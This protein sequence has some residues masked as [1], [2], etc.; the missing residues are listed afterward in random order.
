MMTPRRLLVM[1]TGFG[2]LLTAYITYA[3]FLGH[4]GDFQP[5]PPDFR[6][7][8]TTDPLISP[9]GPRQNQLMAKLEEAFGANCEESRR[10]I[11]LQ[12]PAQ[13][14]VMAAD[15]YLITDGK[16]KLIRVSVAQFGKPDAQ[17]RAVQINSMR[18]DLA[19][20][21][22]EKPITDLQAA[23]RLKP[24]AG[25][26]DGNVR[27]HNN[28]GTP[29]I[30][31][32]LHVFA[33]WLAFRDD[34]HRIWTDGEVVLKDHDPEQ[35]M[36]KATGLEVILQPSEAAPAPGR[37]KPQGPS[38]A[39]VKYVRLE[40]NVQ[41]TTQI[42]GASSFLGSRKP[43]V[44][45][46][47][48]SQVADNSNQASPRGGPAAP[49]LTQRTPLVITC[50]G[51]FVFYEDPEHDRAEFH[52]RVTVIRTQEP[53][54]RGNSTQ[55][56]YDQLDCDKLVLVFDRKQAQARKPR[57]AGA[58][59]TEPDLVSA[60]ATGAT[61]ELVSDAEQLHATG[62]DMYYDRAASTTTLRG[63]PVV[64]ERAGHQMRV[65]GELVLRASPDGKE[66]HEAHA[67]GPG[68]IRL[69]RENQPE[70]AARWR[71]ELVSA[72]DG[73]LDKLTLNG[74]AS[75][76]DPLRGRL[77]A[78]QL[79]VWIDPAGAGAPLVKQPDPSSAQKSP[80]V[81]AVPAFAKGRTP[82]RLEATGNVSLVAA[83][84]V[85]P[86]TDRLRLTFEDAKLP[87]PAP[88]LPSQLEPAKPPGAPPPPAAPPP[89][90]TAR[91]QFLPA[92]EV[93]RRE[94]IELS[95]RLVDVTIAH[96]GTRA[97]LKELRS[98]GQ[99]QILQ[100]A[101]ATH[102][103]SLDIKGERLQLQGISGAYVMHVIGQPG[104]PAFVQLERLSVMGPTVEID[105]LKNEVSVE[106]VG[107]MKIP[108]KTDFQG[109]ALAE[110]ADVT[111]FW[112]QRM[113]FDGR[114]AEFDD[115]KVGGVVAVQGPARLTCRKLEVVLDHPVSLKGRS[116]K[117]PEPGLY[118]IFCDQ[119]VRMERGI[120]AEEASLRPGGNQ[121]NKP[122]WSEFQRFEAT[123]LAF[124]KTP[125]PDLS[126]VGPGLVVFLGKGTAR[127]LTGPAPVPPAAAPSKV[128]A[129]KPANTEEEL[130]L[131]RIHYTG[132]MQA[133]QPSKDTTIVKFFDNIELLHLAASDPDVAVNV[134]RLP[135]GAIHVQCNRLELLN[136]KSAVGP[137]SSL[138]EA[139]DRVR[140]HSREFHAFADRVTYDESKDL[141]VLEGV[142]ASSAIIHRQSRPG[143]PREPIAAKK[144]RVWV[145][146]NRVDFDGV[147]SI[148]LNP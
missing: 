46:G 94:P 80:G 147:E 36:V 127:S 90:S 123:E 70:V 87:S 61:V 49:K 106:G 118:R 57:P 93:A 82:R 141:L 31:D 48:V 56:R 63:N 52:D 44:P 32:D 25:R 81:T 28:R 124:E 109:N 69:H 42:E 105:Q 47:A 136:R 119:D 108:S 144:I 85:I 45:S 77:Q 132:Q 12:W 68:E 126:T 60:R 122:R 143:G 54:P 3:H 53:D 22:F 145:R 107:S 67:R 26:L 14:V 117:Q 131:T 135:T 11:K 16:L 27:L 112:N 73:G 83:E 9:Q 65:R 6:P 101:A 10:R 24:T 100:R 76:E 111:I 86:R 74:Q 98:E 39:G 17:T 110:A 121:P 37:Q 91:D 89:P 114:L 20:V 138:F 139:R 51:A 35:R 21:E 18:S 15:Q 146:D 30:N 102:E 140:V 34:Q 75:F 29:E 19:V 13:G 115:G 95:A 7:G 50:Q 62:T 99:V 137:A 116:E 97:E 129:H 92:P 8:Q 148:R 120:R 1:L 5:L 33:P 130:K 40:R 125:E 142:G 59:A 58:P 72:K 55:L 41:M 71:D 96:N 128:V 79:C 113:F 103:K 4:Y 134:D 43:S 23:A 133:S 2:V 64:A 78:E 104:E 88:P 66:L 38:F 84:L